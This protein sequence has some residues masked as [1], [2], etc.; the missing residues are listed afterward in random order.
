[1]RAAGGPWNRSRAMKGSSPRFPTIAVVA[2]VG[3]I[4]F[5]G[6]GCSGRGDRVLG[7]APGL[8]SV[9][10]MEA[11][12]SGGSDGVTVSGV[13]IEK[14]PEAGCWFVLKDST[15]RMKVDTK[16]AG[17]VVVD[18]P[19]NRTITAKGQVVTN[20]SEVLFS[21]TGIRY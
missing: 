21:A 14:C 2:L 3:L 1:M 7:E 19:L 15:G 11:R 17:F 5:S 12:V 20:G 6:A 9:T 10:L 13:M 16:M 18:V 4:G 8:T